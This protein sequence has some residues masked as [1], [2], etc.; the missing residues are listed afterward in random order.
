MPSRH[1][2]MPAH[3]LTGLL[4]GFGS[5]LTTTLLTAVPAVPATAA[6]AAPAA[7]A[8]SAA[9]EDLAVPV[10]ATTCE[11]FLR[12]GVTALGKSLS[13]TYPKT[14]YRVTRL[15][16]APSLDEQRQGRVVSWKVTV[17]KAAQVKQART[18]LTG[19]LAT[20]AAGHRYAG[21]R[22]LGVTRVVW[23]D[24]EWRAD[25]PDA[26]WR[27]YSTCATRRGSADDARCGRS[28]M[29]IALSWPGALKETSRWTGK[30]AATD[31]GPCRP[32]D[33]SWGY[34]YQERQPRPC[35]TYPPLALPGTATKADREL[36]AWS[37]V[38]LLEGSTG[39]PVRVLQRALRI[40]VNGRFG[41]ATK[42]SLR[43]W[44]HKHALATSGK[45]DSAT[46][47]AL[48]R[49]TL[50]VPMTTTP[51]G[52]TST[53]PPTT[54]APPTTAPPTAPPTATPPTAPPAT[55][56][57]P[58]STMPPTSS[59]DWR[60]VYSQDFVAPAPV[61]S[62]VTAK[63]DDWYLQPSHPYA[64]ALR[65]YPDGWGTTGNLSL[66]YA[67]KTTD[68]VTQDHDALGVLRLRAHTE[69][70]G[71]QQRSLA[72]SFFAVIDPTASGSA[73]VAQTYGRYSVRFRTVGGYPTQGPGA[74]YGSAFLLWPADDT[75]SEGEVDFPEMAWGGKVGG[76]V[77][78]V[79]NPQV[80][81]AVVSSP[82]TTEGDWHVATIEWRPDA[83]VFSLDGKVLQTVTHDVPTKPFR[84]GFQSGGHDG[85]PG[86]GV[87]GQLLVDWITI[88]AWTGRR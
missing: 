69:T 2:A 3:R 32:A 23:D 54:T 19:L 39:E 67:S 7:S 31:F 40:R 77:H 28:T 53:V 71:G 52:P 6:P 9:I 13:A 48:L 45:T 88:D 30:V 86:P 73:Q 64:N 4:L 55:T 62:F 42:A 66:N 43:A 37:G 41:T 35:P 79:G 75:W 50:S 70:V 25:A 18:M 17:H 27:A 5:L 47:R 81:A 56:A 8:A 84:W 63:K 80:N 83:L 14:G 51:S 85:T 68:V 46:W 11:P 29:Q 57:P 22:R 36:V 76:Y 26:G 87:E 1:S 58:T 12:A 74:R 16:D 49:A 24:R 15:C 59:G 82:T 38:R 20:D 60:R 10:P 78:T 33:L 61:G 21:A 72:G 34:R 44:Q 65:T